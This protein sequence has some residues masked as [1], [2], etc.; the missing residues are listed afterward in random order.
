MPKQTEPLASPSSVEITP[1]VEIAGVAAG[2]IPSI[3]PL[4][5]DLMKSATLRSGYLPEDFLDDL[6]NGFCQMVI[7]AE[8]NGTLHAVCITEI[9]EDPTPKKI[10]NIRVLAGKG[11]G[12]WL[13]WLP[14][15]EAWAKN[16]G[17]D[18]V[19]VAEGRMGWTRILKPNGY[20]PVAVKLKKAL[21]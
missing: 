10:C 9:Y 15:M 21:K 2:T 7:A 14:Q 17:C 12:N 13:Q 1:E 6:L 8:K 16:K 5:Y 3:W 18:E 19:E 11:R 4:V 20:K